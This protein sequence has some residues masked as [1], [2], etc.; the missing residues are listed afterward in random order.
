MNTSK[1]AIFISILAIA[2]LLVLV[3]DANRQIANLN[4]EI[5]SIRDGLDA[6]NN[7]IGALNDNADF[8][9]REL[10]NTKNNL[11]ELGNSYKSDL[12]NS[13]S[14]GCYIYD[15][16]NPSKTKDTTG[17]SIC[18]ERGTGICLFAI[19]SSRAGYT[20]FIRSCE[21]FGGEDETVAYCCDV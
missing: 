10:N 16:P 2:I 18:E 8:L 5:D 11:D 19:D 3:V 12:M 4:E 17:N 20:D 7:K 9:G 15:L 21:Y 14:F 6:Q 13:L 1:L